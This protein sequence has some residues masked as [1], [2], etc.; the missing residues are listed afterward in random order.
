MLQK[1]FRRFSY[2]GATTSKN[3]RKA[4]SSTLSSEDAK[5]TASKRKVLQGAARDL[6]RNF[7]VAA[8]AIRKHLDFV[9]AFK[10]QSRT[11]DDGLDRE[12][13]RLMTWWQ[14][15]ENCDVAGRHGLPR[16]LRLAEE[17]RTVDG[18]VFL[19]KLTGQRVRGK[20]QAIESD[21]VVDPRRDTGR[22]SGEN[23]VHGVS[24]NDAGRALGYAVHKRT[25]GGRGLEMDRVVPAR[26]VIHHG[27]YDRF[28]QVRGV[29]PLAPAVNAFRDV[30]EAADYALA[31]AKVS[32]MFG[33]VFYREAID[34][35]G[36]LDNSTDPYEVDF[37]SGPVLLDLE[38]GDKAEFLESKTPSSEFQSFSQLMISLA[39]KSLDI[40]FSFFDESFTNFYGSRGALLH[41]QKSCEAK[42]AD[43]K[44]VLRKLT[45]WRM[46]LWIDDGVL[47]LPSGVSLSDLNWEWIPAGLAWWDPAKEIRGD[48]E[49]INAGL[50]TR[51]EIRAEK[52]GDDWIDVVDQ[53]ARER[54]ALK[55][56]GLLVDVVAPSDDEPEQGVD[57]AEK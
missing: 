16:L 23:W 36:T 48:V 2:D 28:D 25:R 17:R 49:A 42:R 45:A 5:L 15:P 52:Y 9:A 47:S 8:W 7:S 39:L 37:G 27:F 56:R 44:D 18:D 40:P 54:V 4:A 31:K 26:N 57:D 13:E 35:A 1:L 32:Q 46:S 51:S 24:V 50:R 10:F 6:S 55:E 53:L 33:L 21:R 20:I 29:S 41:Y 22:P 34:A 38:P 43:V 12:I 11:G 3:Q 19:M 14:R 30:Y